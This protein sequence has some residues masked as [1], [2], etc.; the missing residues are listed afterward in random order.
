MHLQIRAVPAK[1]PPN[2]AEFLQV[3]ADAKIN[4]VAA[5]GGYVESGGEF[6]FAVEDG[7]EDAAMA[8]LSLDYQPRLVRPKRCLL[9]DEPGQLLSCITDAMAE[10][11][12][13]KRVIKD[14]LVGAEKEDGKVIVQVWSEEPGPPPAS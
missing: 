3:L 1:S 11:A 14:I 10:N 7:Q 2:L 4:L 6:V 12:G 9:D 8:A 5:G 13:S